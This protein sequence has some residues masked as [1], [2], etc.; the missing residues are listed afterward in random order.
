MLLGDLGADVIKVEKPG[1][2]DENRRMRTYEG[3]HAHDEDYF[4]PM[5]RNKKSIEIDLKSAQDK[6]KL[7]RLIVQADVVIE[8]FTPGTMSHL[9]L[10]YKHLRDV[11]PRL[12]YCSISGFGQEGPFRNRKA[13]D[14]I[15]QAISG[16]MAM[17]GEP[18]GPPLRSGIMFGDL[19]GALYA[20]G[21]IMVSLYAREKTGK[22]NYIDLS[23]SD[24]L[25]SLYCT[26]AAEY[27]ANGHVPQPA[28]S[29]NP[30]RSPTGAYRCA[31]GRY[32]QVM[33]GSPSLWPKFCA[34]L[35]LDAIRDDP[36][37]ATNDQRVLHRREL[38]ALLSPIIA[39][40]PSAYWEE[41]FNSQGIPCAPIYTVDDA[42]RS[43][44]FQARSMLL[45]HNHPVSG[46]I[47]TINNPFRFS[48]YQTWKT[49]P[50][51]LLGEHNN[52]FHDEHD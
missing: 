1:I 16:V 25:L 9:G 44:H 33:G 12:I 11:N 51:P 50:P 28:G 32:V 21:S 36:R 22:G 49:S 38:R 7:L 29:E 19:T 13:Y 48:E 4:Y 18:D 35:G 30:G 20:L 14:S 2:G 42:L 31:D 39:D 45:E 3:R 47:R 24:A 6:R 43:P 40:R 8:N 34:I 41:L 10:D 26:T 5:N 15:I 46:V 52:L 27:L 17:T 23:L 37:F